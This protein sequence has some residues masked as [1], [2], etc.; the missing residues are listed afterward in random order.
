[1]LHNAKP[2]KI[3]SGGQ[4][5]TD[6]GALIAALDRGVPCGGWCPPGREAED[7]PISEFFPLREL[8]DSDDQLRTLQNVR[9]SDA[10]CIVQFDDPDSA[11]KLAT[12]ACRRE[13]KPYFYLDARELD[14]ELAAQAIVD[15]VR[16]NKITCL[17]VS[18][19]SAS[20]HP[21]SQAWTR[22]TVREFLLSLSIRR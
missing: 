3:I 12:A 6:R 15:F 17:N 21:A 8:P 22:A 7:G 18:G 5:G 19:P 20:L 4:T 11:A 10:T 1:M 2:I 14:F 9:D 13:N 16:E